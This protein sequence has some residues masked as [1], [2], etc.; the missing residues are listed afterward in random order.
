[1]EMN[2]LELSVVAVQ[3]KLVAAYSKY[4]EQLCEKGQMTPYLQGKLE[5]Y[6]KLLTRAKQSVNGV[7]NITRNSDESTK[8]NQTKTDQK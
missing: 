1:M 4:I 8:T 2:E 6:S 3:A 7:K 5:E